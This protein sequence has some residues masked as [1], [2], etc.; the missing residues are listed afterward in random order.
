MVTASEL[1][2]LAREFGRG[3]LE[4]A[5]ET[6]WSQR[7]DIPEPP[8]IEKSATMTEGDSAEN[9]FAMLSGAVVTGEN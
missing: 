3:G 8:L 7:E 5:D 9:V 1:E 6:P 4:S 2:P